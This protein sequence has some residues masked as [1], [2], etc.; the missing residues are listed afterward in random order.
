MKL[1]DNKQLVKLFYVFEEK[2][3]KKFYEKLYAKMEKI[4]R[5]IIVFNNV[6]IRNND[7]YLRDTL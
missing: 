7:S 1:N 6:R 4:S 5:N 2:R 3:I